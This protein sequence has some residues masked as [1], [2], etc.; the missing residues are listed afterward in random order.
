MVWGKSVV[1]VILPR[2]HV[3][4]AIEGHEGKPPK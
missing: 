4:I 2:P 3:L 1:S